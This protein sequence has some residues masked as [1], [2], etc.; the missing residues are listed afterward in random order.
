MSMPSLRAAGAI[1][2][3]HGITSPATPGENQAHLSLPVFRAFIEAAREMGQLV[4]L[5]ELIRRHVAGQKTAGLIAIT[6]DDAY[7]SLLGEAT[8]FLAREAIPL[9]VFVVTQ[10]AG[11]GAIY[12]WDRVDDVFPRVP[13]AQW[14]AF[15]DACGLT[16]DYRRGQPASFGPLRPFRQWMLATH[17]GRWPATLEQ[18]LRAL[19]REFRVSTAQRSMH[20]GELAG[21]ATLPGV[22]VGL[23][24]LSHPVL[25]LLSDQE[26]TREI[27]AGYQ[28]LREH[29]PNA[30]P[31]LALP[32]S[33]F[34]LRTL[35]AARAA[36]MAASLTL[37]GATLKRYAGRD[38]LPRFCICRGD[39]LS[40][41][42]ARLT[43][44]FDRGR[45]WRAPARQFPALPSATT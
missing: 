21:F 17:R 28:I 24:T 15:E 4:P 11:A 19:E 40:R 27:S 1:L 23:H 42:R 33:L 8:D 18:P 25:P 41:L 7:A 36:V 31:V 14:R 39:R 45:W 13:E 38:D 43:G 5:R 35:V 29:F 34:D 26:L 6:A 10:P 37:A 30:V 12:W 22:D 3:F 9:T 2:C 44:F 16:D 20:L 32:F